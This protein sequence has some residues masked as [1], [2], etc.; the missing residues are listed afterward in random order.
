MIQSVTLSNFQTHENRTFEFEPGLNVVTG[1]SDKGK[2]ALVRALFWLSQHGNQNYTRHGATECSVSATT[3][4]G[5]VTRF[6]GK[7]NGYT[8]NQDTY[9]AVGTEQP[10]PVC[11][12]LPLSLMNFQQQ[13]DSPFLL[14]LS[15]GQTAKEINKIVDLSVID[16]CVSW[17][18]KT[19]A[20]E[21]TILRAV[22][23]DIQDLRTKQ[24]NLSWVPAAQ[25]AW[26]ALEVIRETITRIDTRISKIETTSNNIREVNITGKNA[27]MVAKAL[28]EFLGTVPV[29]R[30]D[31]ELHNVI[32][33]YKESSIKIAELDGLLTAFS[34]F[35]GLLQQK[36]D[37]DTR[38]MDVSNA[39]SDI[40][41][42]GNELRKAETELERLE[43]LLGVCP[44]CNQPFNRDNTDGRSGDHGGKCKT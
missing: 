12:V 33:S 39:I 21:T 43:G 24:E 27:S 30:D 6:R 42:S 16:A 37:N 3:E 9:V 14:S 4:H 1:A 41:E 13:H 32:L 15:P 2:S 29:I 19:L 31:R 44:V 26:N 8:V 36:R 40:L 23:D 38:Y 22:Q 20:K 11:Q 5:T 18:K 28:Q 7:K 35:P 25:E 34:A 10:V 17:C